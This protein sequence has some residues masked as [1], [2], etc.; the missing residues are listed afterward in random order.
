MPGYGF[1]LESLQFF[2]KG[3]ANAPRTPLPPAVALNLALAVVAS[4]NAPMPL[5]DS[6]LIVIAASKSFYRAFQIES[7]QVE[8]RSLTALGGGEWN[9]PQLTGLLKATASGFAALDGYEME[10]IRPGRDNRCLVLNATKL[11]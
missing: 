7:G 11:A 4:S 10:L 3:V 2:Q 6:S 9:V 5:L 8:G 1:Q